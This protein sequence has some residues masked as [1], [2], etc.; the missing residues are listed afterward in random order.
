VAKNL[1]RTRLTDATQRPAKAHHSYPTGFDQAR[2]LKLVPS[3]I[4]RQ[5]R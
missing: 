3:I 5:E 1:Y 4:D 2:H